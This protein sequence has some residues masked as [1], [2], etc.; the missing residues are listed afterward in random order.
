M[1]SM[2]KTDNTECNHGRRL[3]SA[4]RF[5]PR[6]HRDGVTVHPQL[7]GHRNYLRA[8]RAAEMAA[9]EAGLP[10]SAVTPPAEPN[11]PAE[12]STDRDQLA[13]SFGTFF[14]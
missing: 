11:T 6:P 7:R 14:F 10:L 4:A 3:A 9:W 1:S 8:L 2:P 13:N 12:P 5:A